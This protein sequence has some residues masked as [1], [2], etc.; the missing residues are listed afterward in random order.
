LKR[1]PEEDLIFLEIMKMS[2]NAKKTAHT[3]SIRARSTAII[4]CLALML[5][6][7]STGYGDII[8]GNFENPDSNDNW[9]PGWQGSPVLTPAQTTGVTLGS[10]SLAVQF[11]TGPGSR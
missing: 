8:I 7:I 4:V 2:S 6:L 3:E 10:G 11:T 9:V 5:G 1:K